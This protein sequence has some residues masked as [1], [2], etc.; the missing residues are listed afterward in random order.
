MRRRCT[1][2]LSRLTF[3][4]E[5]IRIVQSYD[6]F[7]TTTTSSRNDNDRNVIRSEIMPLKGLTVVAL[8]Q[9]VAAPYCSSRLA[10]AGKYPDNF[11]IVTLRFVPSQEYI[12]NRDVRTSYVSNKQEHE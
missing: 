1:T 11:D 7:S 6:E 3:K 12:S 5:K 2:L 8:E 9:A 10:D 4:R